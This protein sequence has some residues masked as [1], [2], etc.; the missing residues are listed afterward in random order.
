[1][2][3]YDEEGRGSSVF[4]Q[5]SILSDSPDQFAHHHHQEFEE[6]DES[7]SPSPSRIS[8]FDE[9]DDVDE[10]FDD[11]FDYGGLDAM[12]DMDDEE[13]LFVN[14]YEDE[15]PIELPLIQQQL[16][17]VLPRSSPMINQEP[18]FYSR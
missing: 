11:L 15:G 16:A 18:P 1:M 8:S 14:E 13:S 9:E 2:S 7:L 10:E 12:V 4:D 5:E 17:Q 6:F 3:F